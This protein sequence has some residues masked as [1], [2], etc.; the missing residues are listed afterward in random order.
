MPDVSLSFECNE[1]RTSVWRR[2]LAGQGLCASGSL[3]DKRDGDAYSIETAAG[4]SRDTSRTA[5]S[6]CT[7]TT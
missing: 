7:S 1:S 6:F 3:A 5:S 4:G 2:L